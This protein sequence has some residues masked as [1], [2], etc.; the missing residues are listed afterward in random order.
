MYSETT[1]IKE[2]IENVA[3]IATMLL[4]IEFTETLTKKVKTAAHYFQLIQ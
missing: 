2:V 4:N 3:Q 1:Y